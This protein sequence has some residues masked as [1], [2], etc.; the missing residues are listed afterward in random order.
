[1]FVAKPLYKTGDVTRM[2][3]ALAAAAPA[4]RHGQR[5]TWNRFKTRRALQK[6]GLPPRQFTLVE[7]RRAWPELA[8]VLLEPAAEGRAA[9]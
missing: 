5:P 3:N 6:R 2:L 7:L 1:M 8:E 4:D 9:A